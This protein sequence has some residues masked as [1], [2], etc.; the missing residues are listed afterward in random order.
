MKTLVG[1]FGTVLTPAG[2]N[3]FCKTV[4]GSSTASSTTNYSSL[5][6]TLS[7]VAIMH[8]DP[9]TACGCVDCRNCLRAQFRKVGEVCTSVFFHSVC[10]SISAVAGFPHTLRPQLRYQQKSLDVQYAAYKFCD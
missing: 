9:K 3:H 6:E 1:A 8:F 5:S 7:S 10:L 4:G 2:H